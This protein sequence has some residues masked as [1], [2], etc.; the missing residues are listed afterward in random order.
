MRDFDLM[1]A[2]GLAEVARLMTAEPKLEVIGVRMRSKLPHDRVERRFVEE[3]GREHAAAALEEMPHD[4]RAAAEA[5]DAHHGHPH[6]GDDR[7]R[8]VGSFLRHGASVDPRVGGACGRRR[9]PRG[10][11]G[12]TVA[13][14]VRT[15][16]ASRTPIE[17]C[18][19]PPRGPEVP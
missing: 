1:T 10:S 19:K 13:R 2:A 14:S 3:I 15:C 17:T 6:V 11:R 12:S 8:V 7:R 18:S 16:A 4:P 9:T 5:A